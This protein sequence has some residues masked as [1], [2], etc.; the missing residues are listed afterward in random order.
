MLSR[1]RILYS[2]D[3]S[4][5]RELVKFVLSSQGFDVVATDNH[6]EALSLA[7]TSRFDL[8]L[9]DSWMPGMSGVDLCKELRKFDES[10]PILFNSGAVFAKDKEEAFEAGAQGYLMKPT[11]LEELIAEVFRLVGSPVQ[12][13]V[14][15][16][17]STY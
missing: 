16:D 17:A 1:R 10:T 6:C 13:S 4:D 8:Y 7:R 2:E 5:T 14:T 12:D 15:H 9:I 3:H 11:D